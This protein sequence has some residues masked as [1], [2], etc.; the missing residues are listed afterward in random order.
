MHVLGVI[1]LAEQQHGADA[2]MGV[3]AGALELRNGVVAAVEEGL[4]QFKARLRVRGVVF[5]ALAAHG[6]LL[7]RRFLAELDEL[8]LKFLVVRLRGGAAADFLHLGLAVALIH[9]RGLVFQGNIIVA[10][11]ERVVVEGIG[12][13]P[14]LHLFIDAGDVAHGGQV[15]LVLG[16]TGGKEPK[17]FF[18]LRTGEA[19]LVALVQGVRFRG[20][21]HHVP[22]A[23]GFL[24]L[25]LLHRGAGHAVF[26][27]LHGHAVRGVQLH[28][29]MVHLSSLG[30]HVP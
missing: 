21:L 15:L 13:R 10:E 5:H 28:E 19:L 26:F 12:I 3:V 22:E 6:H 24:P 27:T 7:F 30:G 4:P 17:A 16:I 9:F 29:V 8:F 20:V 2:D 11:A 25:L 14:V 23:L 1:A 18:Q